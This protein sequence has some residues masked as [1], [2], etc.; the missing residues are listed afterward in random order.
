M[1]LSFFVAAVL[2]LLAGGAGADHRLDAVGALHQYCA[3]QGST[4]HRSLILM[5]QLV[6]TDELAT[7]GGTVFVSIYT[8]QV[9]PATE[10]GKLA[11]R[12]RVV[13]ATGGRERLG[14]MV[15]RPMGEGVL[16]GEMQVP[17]ALRRGDMILWRYRFHGFG[18]LDAEQCFLLIGAATKP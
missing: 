3:D 17:V 15:A 10:N 5:R 18:D 6:T 9:S 8:P 2:A 4:P 12:V 7:F 13:R 16:K 11:V 1:S 14:K